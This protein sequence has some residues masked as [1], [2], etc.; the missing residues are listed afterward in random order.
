MGIWDKDKRT[1]TNTNKLH[2]KEKIKGMF[3]G[4]WLSALYL[5]QDPKF[6]LKNKMGNFDEADL[7]KAY[8]PT[9]GKDEKYQP[10]QVDHVR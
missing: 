5:D 7:Q 4:T 1:F 3:E 8:T 6:T 9:Q 2:D 10:I